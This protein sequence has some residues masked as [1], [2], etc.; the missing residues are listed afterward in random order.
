MKKLIISNVSQWFK[1]RRLRPPKIENLSSRIKI[2]KQHKSV[3]IDDETELILTLLRLPKSRTYYHYTSIGSL[4]GII[5]SK[6][7]LVTSAVGLNDSTEMRT[8]PTIFG[9]YEP[10]HQFRKERINNI[11]NRFVFSFSQN[12]DDL[13][14]WRL[15]GDDA[16]GVCLCFRCEPKACNKNEYFGTVE[17]GKSLIESFKSLQKEIK[18]K[19]DYELGYSQSAVWGYFFKG[20]EWQDEKEIRFLKVNKR[21]LGIVDL[22][23]WNVNRY[24]IIAPKISISLEKLPFKLTIILGPKLFH[25]E[26]NKTLLRL[27]LRRKE[28]A[29]LNVPILQSEK[30]SYR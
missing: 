15:Y 24:G 21:G 6:T 5:N 3:W 19:F 11:S 25:K 7:L 8:R 20:Q 4:M 13:N 27:M 16:R 17:Y 18:E 29:L 9:D 12:K 1:E 22:N 28:N 2:S 10:I 14:Q 26:L 23:H 30:L